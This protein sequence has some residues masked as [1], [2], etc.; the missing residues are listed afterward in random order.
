VS[1]AALALA[2][3]LLVPAIHVTASPSSTRAAAALGAAALAWAV[4]MFGAISSSR[5]AVL[6]LGIGVATFAAALD[7]VGA[8]AA[9]SL[10]EAL[11]WA[12][13]GI[14]FARFFDGPW[15]AVTVP[16]LV[17]GITAAGVSASRGSL[18]AFASAGDPLTLEL[19]MFGGGQSFVIPVIDAT[20]LGALVTWSRSIDVRVP[21]TAVLVIEA[22]ALAAALDLEPLVF[23]V[24]AFIGPNLDRALAA[25]AKRP[26]RG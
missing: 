18:T 2:E 25:M 23:L 15:A 19:P 3:L 17:A 22:A 7:S 4:I 13:L 21:W 5:F 11:A 16:L 10:P 12:S 14:I 1:T 6:V 24:V 8:R 26:L 9:A 20:L